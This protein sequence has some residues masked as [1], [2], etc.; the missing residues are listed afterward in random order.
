M[1]M[2]AQSELI[3]CGKSVLKNCKAMDKKCIN[4]KYG[5][6]QGEACAQSGIVLP[7]V[8]PIKDCS[9]YKSVE[10]VKCHCL[11]APNGSLICP[12]TTEVEDLKRTLNYHFHDYEIVDVEIN[13]EFVCKQKRTEHCKNC[14]FK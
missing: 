11:R 6:H 3:E 7:I 10:V 14:P 4:C 1:S 8:E 5:R 2:T 13:K 9:F 12:L